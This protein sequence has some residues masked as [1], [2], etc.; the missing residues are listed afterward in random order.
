LSDATDALMGIKKVVFEDKA[1]TMDELLNALKADW[2]GYD[3]LRAKCLAAPKFG[4]DDDEAD[5]LM[6]DLWQYTLDLGK[7]TYRDP[8]GRRGIQLR[9]GAGWAQWAGPK[10]GA[11]P[12]GRKA[13]TNLADASAS[14]VQ[15]AD[16]LGPTAVLNSVSKLDHTDLEGPLLNMKLT[17]GPLRS[18]E[19]RE[20]FAH[21][22]GTYFDKGGYHVQ[23]T[24]L[25]RKTLLDAKEHPEEYRNLVVR[26]AGYSAFW[27]ELPDVLQ[28]EIIS[29]SEHQV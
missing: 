12:S 15:G 6:C 16:R 9:Q 20:K 27:V 17:P 25:D 8:C 21:L 28:N 29:R 5:A 14:P 1:A 23:F 18:K 7:A 2:E 11:L 19:G 13:W 4:N 26:V 22:L 10:T 24:V 3:E